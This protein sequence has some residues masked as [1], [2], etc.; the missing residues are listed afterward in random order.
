M[1]TKNTKPAARAH[2]L[3]DL[4]HDAAATADRCRHGGPG[5]AESWKRPETEYEARSQHHVEEVREPQHPHRDSGIAGAPENR[6]NEIK[7]H[8]D[9]IAAQHDAGVAGAV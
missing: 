3:H 8:D 6:V 7:H 2:K 9:E 1:F 4:V 5:Y